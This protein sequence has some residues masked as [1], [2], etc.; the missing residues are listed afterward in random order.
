MMPSILAIIVILE[1]MCR[2]MLAT[3]M[4]TLLLVWEPQLVVVLESKHSVSWLP[5]LLFQKEPLCHLAKS[6]LV[7]QLNTCVTFL[8]KRST[9]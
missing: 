1:Q 8:K 6:G 7:L 2:S 9:L 5:V 4:I 3:L